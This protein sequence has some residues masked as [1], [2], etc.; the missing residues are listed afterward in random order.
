MTLKVSSPSL[1]VTFVGLREKPDTEFLF[2][3]FDFA[4]ERRLCEVQ[5]YRGLGEAKRFGHGDEVMQVPNFHSGWILGYIR[6][7]SVWPYLKS[8]TL[9]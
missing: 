7:R 9:C 1:R 8:I 2:Q 6:S 4:R 5:H 3:P